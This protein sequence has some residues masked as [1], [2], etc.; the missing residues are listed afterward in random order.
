MR[1]FHPAT[2]VG[3]IGSAAVAFGLF[4]IGTYVLTLGS[5]PGLFGLA[6]AALGLICMALVFGAT[7]RHRKS[8]AFLI[9][10]WC[11]VGF[12]AFFAAP[13]VLTLPKVKPPHLVKHGDG[14]SE[15]TII[16]LK[17]LG[18]CLGFAAPFAL[19]CTSFAIGRRDYERTA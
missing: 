3:L 6:L 12:C 7:R 18:I 5:L 17:V 19:A 15:N 9:A 1:P 2:T 10:S 8:W 13:K 4:A 16:K 11:V 14:L